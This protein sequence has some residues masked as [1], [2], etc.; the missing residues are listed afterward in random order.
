MN[1]FIC[2]FS[3][4]G[5]STLLSELANDEDLKNYNFIDLDDYILSRNPKFDNLGDLI[6]ERGFD[7]FRSAEKFYLIE[8][9]LKTNQIVALGGGA[10]NPMTLKVLGKWQGLWLD[11]DFETCYGRIK[12]DQNRPMSQLSKEELL[13]LY[14]DRKLVFE[15]RE[16]IK[17]HVFHSELFCI[18]PDI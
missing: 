17:L 15:T 14:E 6:K 7:F 13:K 8:L 18:F 4:A 9:G 12:E 5:K 3:G 10:L 2:G 16:S 1:Y 11:V